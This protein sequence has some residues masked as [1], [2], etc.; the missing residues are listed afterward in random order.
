[1]SSSYQ[2]CSICLEPMQRHQ[3][4]YV[5]RANPT[6]LSTKAAEVFHMF[7]EECLKNAE[8]TGHQH[9]SLCRELQPKWLYEL[10]DYCFNDQ[11]LSE[12]FA[13]KNL[14]A[15][16]KILQSKSF[17]ENR[18]INYLKAAGESRDM[19]TLG[20]LLQKGGFNE[21]VLADFI[22][23]FTETDDHEIIRCVAQNAEITPKIKNILLG[24]AV[25]NHLQDLEKIFNA[26]KKTKA[27]IVTSTNQAMTKKSVAFKVSCV[28]LGVLLG[29]VGLGSGMWW[30]FGGKK[31][32]I[33]VMALSPLFAAGG[34]F[35]AYNN[36]MTK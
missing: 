20:V 32:G 15:A 25:A 5:H 34:G 21:A 16:K 18:L 30:I 1:M 17:A 28:A 14:E 33:A 26:P 12:A 4:L 27:L 24:Y 22:V 29:A 35:C 31:A 11:D 2:N 36:L 10:G 3:M 19:D 7:H 9:C 8:K 13:Q 6:K 23:R